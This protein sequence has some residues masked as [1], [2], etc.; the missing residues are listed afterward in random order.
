MNGK[1]TSVDCGGGEC[2]ACAGGKSCVVGHDCESGV[3]EN[4]R[5]SKVKAAEDKVGKEEEAGREEKADKD[6]EGN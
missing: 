4:T 5:C 2:D 6:E 1:E 3:C